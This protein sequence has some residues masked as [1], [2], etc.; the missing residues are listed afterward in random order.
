LTVGLSARR[1]AW[2][3]AARAPAADDADGRVLSFQASG[4][5]ASVEAALQQGLSEAG[6][7][8]HRNVAIGAG[9]DADTTTS[10]NA[11]HDQLNQ[12]DADEQHRKRHHIVFEPMPII[13]KHH[14]HPY[15]NAFDNRLVHQH[16]PHAR[17]RGI[18][19][20]RFWFRGLRR[21]SGQRFAICGGN[22]AWPIN[23]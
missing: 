8:E 1:S 7:V 21:K 9:G 6:Y 23:T 16:L 3:L 5:T 12:S 11:Q 10:S 2:P 19:P 22:P 20:Q 14:V 4:E 17:F 13:A 18:S 15:A